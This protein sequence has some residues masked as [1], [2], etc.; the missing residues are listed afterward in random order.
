MVLDA[1][2]RSRPSRQECLQKNLCF[3]CKKPGHNRMNCAEKQRNDERWRTPQFAPQ[4]Q[5]QQPLPQQQF[6]Q[7]QS[8]QFPQNAPQPQPRIYQPQPRPWT[9]AQH[10]Y[11]GYNQSLPRLRALEHGYVEGEINSNASSVSDHQDTP[12]TESTQGKA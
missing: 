7:R 5:A 2:A 3:Y 1:A 11:R 4:P 8:Q 6:Q 9:P 12:D 10:Q